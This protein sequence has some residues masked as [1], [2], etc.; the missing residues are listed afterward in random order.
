MRAHRVKIYRSGT[1]IQ[2]H[3]TESLYAVA[4]EKR[5]RRDLLD[6]SGKRGDVVHGARFVIDVHNRSK[7]NIRRHELCE[8]LR[9]HATVASDGSEYYVESALFKLR[10]G[11]VHRGVLRAAYD[12][13]AVF[14]LFCAE[15]RYIV[16]FGTSARKNHFSVAA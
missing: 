13:P 3:F 5:V 15:K 7:R 4:V 14:M 10:S 16:A 2:F 1:Q 11:S 6:Y 8:T 9:I 12:D